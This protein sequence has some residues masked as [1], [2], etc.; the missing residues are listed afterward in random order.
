MVMKLSVYLYNNKRGRMSIALS[1]EI[2]G[3]IA[4]FRCFVDQTPALCNI[5]VPVI[6]KS[7]HISKKNHSITLSK[8]D[9]KDRETCE[10]F[11]IPNN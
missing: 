11:T 2:L 8:M 1:V 3:R 10:N 6:I 7:F 4:M 9:V 5:T